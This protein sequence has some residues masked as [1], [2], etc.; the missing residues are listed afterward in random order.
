MLSSA[1]PDRQVIKLGF[2]SCPVN[3][4]NVYVVH[5]GVIDLSG[6]GPFGAVKESHG[7]MPARPLTPKRNQ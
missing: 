5:W 7:S 4:H 3:N 1:A 6:A 2:A